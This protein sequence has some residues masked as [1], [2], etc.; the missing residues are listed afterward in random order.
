MLALLRWRSEKFRTGASSRFSNGGLRR[1]S[2]QE[3]RERGNGRALLY[4][5]QLYRGAAAGKKAGTWHRPKMKARTIKWGENKKIF[6]Q[7][8]RKG[9][10]PAAHFRGQCLTFMRVRRRRFFLVFFFLQ[11]APCHQGAAE[12]TFSCQSDA[13][14]VGRV[15]LELSILSVFFLYATIISRLVWWLFSL[16]FFWI[17]NFFLPICK[18][19]K[20][21]KDSAFNLC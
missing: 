5:S 19:Q 9:A 8:I 11:W 17:A 15:L 1:R 3:T 20:T 12:A 13:D 6:P 21:K 16:L 2:G 14:R 10:L 7:S 18:K 4:F